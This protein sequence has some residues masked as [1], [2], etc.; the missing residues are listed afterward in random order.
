[1]TTNENGAPAPTWA[2][3]QERRSVEVFRRSIAPLLLVL[4]TPGAVIVLWI[5]CTYLDGSLLQLLTSEGLATVVREFPSPSWLAVKMIVLFGGFELVLLELLPGRWHEGPVTPTGHRPRYKL[6][7]VWAWVITH[8][9]F[10]VASYGFGWFSP[11]IVY[12][13]L[14]ELLVTL[15]ASCFVLCWLLYF[16]GIYAPS[17]PDSGSSG[18]VIFDYFW[19]VELHPAVLGVNLKQFLNCRVSMMGWSIMVLSFAAYQRQALGH[20]STAM[21][22]TVVLQVVY[23][24]EFFTWEGGYFAT[25]DVMHDR[26]GYYICWGVLAWVPGVYTITAQYLVKHPRELA[27]PVVSGLFVVGF[28]AIAAGHTADAQ[29]TRVRSLAGETTVW[30]KRP[31]MIHA[32]YTTADGK[33]HQNILLVSGFWGVARHFHYVAELTLALT[34]SLTAG[35][36]HF[37]PYFYWM[38]LTILLVDRAARDDLRCRTKYGRFWDE[39]CRRVPYKILPGIY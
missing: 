38:F 18:N 30:G 21:L 12:E 17:T 22:V 28:A 4:V 15:C 27:W 10:F 9:A 37:L 34:W 31:E 1:M 25:L 35:F 26:F 19:G 8:A 33:K 5:V 16:K 24:F 23:L 29:R 7:A 36:T 32:E 39:Y 2:G 14:G 20:L 11:G 13:H 3:R 6:N